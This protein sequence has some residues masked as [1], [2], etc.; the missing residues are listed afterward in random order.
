MSNN[1]DSDDMTGMYDTNDISQNK[2]LSIVAY[3]PVLFLITWLAAGHSPYAKFNANQGLILTIF[4][5]AAA[6][7]NKF[8]G[9]V[10]GWIPFVGD[11]I[12]WLVWM[13]LSISVLAFMII[14]IVNAAQ[15]KAKKLP[16][17]GDLINAIH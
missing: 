16:F 12:S 17:I 7:I 11:V 10:I 3:I 4:A 15:G 6:I 8:I 1:F 9:F 13:V 5:A 14:G 2:A